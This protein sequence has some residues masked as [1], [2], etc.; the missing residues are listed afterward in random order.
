MSVAQ[1]T[2]QYGQMLGVAFESLILSSCARASV[3]ARFAP[4]PARPPI[5]VPVTVPADSLMK[6][7][8]V[9]FIAAHYVGNRRAHDHRYRRT[10]R[11]RRL[12]TVCPTTWRA[13]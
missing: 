13:L 8:R 3:G 12:R 4:S 1:P 7:R 11:H 9:R 2:E 10:P 6:S 5:A